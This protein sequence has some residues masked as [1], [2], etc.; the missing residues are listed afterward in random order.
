MNEPFTPDGPVAPARAHRILFR[1]GAFFAGWVAFFCYIEGFL[2]RNPGLP[3]QA[4]PLHVRTI[5]SL[6]MGGLVMMA[7]AA[8]AQTLS[9]TRI[10]TVVAGLYTGLLLLVSLLHLDMVELVLPEGEPP[11]WGLDW[12][13]MVSW[14]WFAL[15][16]LCPVVVFRLL[17]TYWSASVAL[18]KDPLP[19]ALRIALGLLAFTG[20]SFALILLLAPELGVGL[21]PW[22]VTPFLL[23]IYAGP[24]LAFAVAGGMMAAAKD[25]EDTRIPAAGLATFAFFAIGASILYLHVLQ[26]FGP[27]ALGWLGFLLVLLLVSI[28][29][30]R[31]STRSKEGQG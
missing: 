21:W 6:Y 14:F 10:P 13:P 5:A 3:F 19:W 25:M 7:L 11:L 24:F 28:A 2:E 17:Q 18:V 23:Q 26:P 15:Y 29:A 22:N 9:A 20:G 1:T 4:P 8:R 12:L 16:A 27:A 31:Q 30:Y